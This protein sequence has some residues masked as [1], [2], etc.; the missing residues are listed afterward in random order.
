MS[1]NAHYLIIQILYMYTASYIRSTLNLVD[2]VRDFQRDRSRL[3]PKPLKTRVYHSQESS[4][5]R[6]CRSRHRKL[7]RL[8]HNLHPYNNI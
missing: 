5:H 6:T 3:Q 7:T 2:G 1:V 4:G 8:V